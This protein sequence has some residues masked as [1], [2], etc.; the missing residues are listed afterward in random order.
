MAF[1]V[2]YVFSDTAADTTLDSGISNSANSITLDSG[3]GYPSPTGGQ[4]AVLVLDPGTSSEEKVYYTG[5][6]GDTLTGVTRGQFGT[7][8]TTHAAGA[9]VRHVLP[10]ALVNEMMDVIL[11]T[12]GKVTTAEDLL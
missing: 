6:S 3:T 4:R 1:D 12:V 7:S 9:T 10:A 5:R 2:D 11:R 8:A